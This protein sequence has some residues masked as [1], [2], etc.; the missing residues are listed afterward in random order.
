MTAHFI[1][2]I[3]FEIWANQ[4]IAEAIENAKEPGE[5]AAYLFSHILSAQSIWLSRMTNSEITT[6][7]FTERNFEESKALMQTVAEKWRAYIT[8]LNEKELSRTIHFVFP[9]DGSKKKI[10]IA[11]AILHNFAH[12][13]YHRGQII[14]LLKGKL[15]PLPLLAYVLFAGEADN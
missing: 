3:E 6:T 5:R 14:S 12:S 13:N 8:H 1:K 9:F 10:K 11:D 7:L 4:K 2:Q 15:E